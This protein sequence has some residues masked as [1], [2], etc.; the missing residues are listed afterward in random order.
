MEAVE[1]D[2]SQTT[3]MLGKEFGFGKSTIYR[4]LHKLGL[5]WKLSSWVPYDLSQDNKDNRVETL[6]RHLQ[7]Q[8]QTPFLN[9][10]F[11]R[12][13]NWLLYK[14]PKR[15]RYWIGKGETPPPTP[16]SV[17][18]RKAMW[19]VWWD[20]GGIVH[21]E[22]IA[23]GFCYWWDDNDERQE[24][25]IP[26]KNGKRQYNLNGEVYTAQLE[27]LHEAI[28]VKRPRKNNHILFHHDN[29][30]P[31]IAQD[32]L[33]AI[34]GYGWELLDHPPYSPDVAPTDYHVNRSVSNW[35]EGE[36]FDSL[37]EIVDSIK[38]WIASKDRK[39][40]ARGIDLLP[41]KWEEM[42]AASG[43]YVNS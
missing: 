13:E 22:L 4:H 40:F 41:Q 28:R 35:M 20:R 29:A 19:C 9:H 21:W 36:M 7:R 43:E 18:C 12:N 11:T 2:S 5:V 42:I 24:W 23:N 14:N 31:H 8:Q 27:R 32:V 17:H 26:D 39:F 34:K 6:R 15:K 30:R 16:K 10:L 37:D 3:R 1:E 38:G 25:R 33:A